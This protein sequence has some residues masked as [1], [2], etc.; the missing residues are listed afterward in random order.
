MGWCQSFSFIFP[1]PKKQR[2]SNQITSN[3]AISKH[4]PISWEHSCGEQ[5][6]QT[7]QTNISQAKWTNRLFQKKRAPRNKTPYMLYMYRRC[8][9]ALFIC[10]FCFCARC[11][12]III[13]NQ[14]DTFTRALRRE[15]SRI[16]CPKMPSIFAFLDLWLLL[17]L[18]KTFM[19]LRRERIW[20]I[21]IRD[22]VAAITLLLGEWLT[23]HMAPL[24]LCIHSCKSSKIQGIRGSN[25]RPQ[26]SRHPL[27]Y[28]LSV[29]PSVPVCGS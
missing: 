14:F 22:R 27:A 7:Y 8:G 16:C 17:Y 5:S 24:L 2:N 18:H 19:N 26:G 29:A 20:K 23:F 6:N 9:F 13:I 1:L 15:C 28:P 12:Y 25:G 3:A 4:Q 11:F 21:A 10:L